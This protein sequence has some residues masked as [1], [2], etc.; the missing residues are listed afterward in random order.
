MALLTP[1][2][3]HG[4]RDLLSLYGLELAEIEALESGSVNSNFFLKAVD[5][6]RFFA[7]LYE[8][9][10]AQGAEFELKLNERL[11]EAQIP[12]ARP[13]RT[14]DGELYCI[15]E[16]PTGRKLPFSVYER[17]EGEI[18]CT[19]R[20]TPAHT[21]VLGD[22]LARVHS[23]P[24]SGLELTPSR[25]GVAGLRERLESIQ[26]S[27]VR[28]WTEAAA[29][30]EQELERCQRQRDPSLGVGLIHGDLFRDNVLFHGET[31][32]GL[33]DF[34]SA[35]LG[36]FMYDLAV[37]ALAWCYA[38]DFRQDC[39]GALLD[40]YHGVRPLSEKERRGLV[41]EARAACVRFAITRITDFAMRAGE[42]ETPK[43]DYRRFLARRRGVDRGAF[44]RAF[45]A[46]SNG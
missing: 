34:E 20:V 17:I 40:G 25:F 21:R 39:L 42:G 10:S 5:G 16:S 32:V 45:G 24:L 29:E 41:Q 1:L 37:T 14:R 23:A 43:R 2:P 26:R 11:G 36:T 46:V 7:R 15:Y 28:E 38:D 13:L 19:Q 44:E 18:L 9:Q 35:S 4:A 8:E 12:V 22:A 3:L 33:L 31:L 27:G 30:L 6:R